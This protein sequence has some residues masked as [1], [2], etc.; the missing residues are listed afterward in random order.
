MIKDSHLSKTIIRAREDSQSGDYME[1][2]LVQKLVK[3]WNKI[4]YLAIKNEYVSVK[5]DTFVQ[6]YQK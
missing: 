5:L 1:E 4:F 3:Q 2:T 6:R